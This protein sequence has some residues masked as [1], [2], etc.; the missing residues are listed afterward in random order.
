MNK[1]LKDFL[2]TIGIMTICF[3]LSLVT[4]QVSRTDMLIPM[5]F[6]LGVFL[7]S[8][9]TSG[10]LWGISASLISVLAVNY[11]FT[12]PYFEFNFSIPVNFFS[13]VVML[14]VAVV[15]CALTTKIKYAEKIKADSEREKMR[16]N[17]L[18]AVSHDL[19]TPLTTIYGSSSMLLDGGDR[20]SADSRRDLLRG[21]RDDAHWLVGMVENLL[22]V[23][24]LDGGELRLNKTDTVLEELVD[25]VL[26]K[27]RK[28][29]PDFD[30]Q[31]TI[32]ED[33]VSIPMD[34]VLIGQVL[35]NLLENAVIHASGM[36]C[37]QLEVRL[38]ENLARF[39]VRDN[40]CGISPDRLSDLFTGYLGSSDRQGDA[41]RRNMGIGLSVCATIIKAHGGQ[42][43]AR[44][45]PGG[46]AEFTFTLTMEE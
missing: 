39:T 27:F 22:S 21:I 17:L 40:G 23:T 1:Q 33:F 8:V 42:I 3:S 18:R 12:F 30:V 28:R 35:T 44:N 2:T 7:I 36:T 32:P 43:S 34:A 45:H 25:A 37:L 38:E 6:V 16:A 15:T 24:R 13:A 9:V 29:C 19:R 26:V 31:V 46:G 10:Y 5:F 11:A 14:V 41:A 20:I 4:D